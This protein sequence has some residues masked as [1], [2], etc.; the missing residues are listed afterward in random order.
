MKQC[1]D[2]TFDSQKTNKKYIPNNEVVRQY[3]NATLAKIKVKQDEILADYASSCRSDVQ[4]CL[5]TNGYDESN[6]S[7]TSSKT[8]VNACSSEITTCMSVGGYQV[9]DGVKLTLRAMSDWV[10]SMLVNCP[11]NTYL[12]DNGTGAV[13]C[14][15]C[16]PVQKS[17]YGSAV[18][19]VDNIPTYSSGGQVT[20]CTCGG[21]YTDVVEYNSSTNLFELKG[22][23]IE[24]TPQSS[25]S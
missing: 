12:K 16:G 23:N 18:T 3:L 8:A 1:Q 6:T 5:S 14:T 13:T 11:V 25:G 21:E 20:R 2:Y 10:A 7:S 17:E 24:V 4:S 22:C 19:G 15:T 9:Q